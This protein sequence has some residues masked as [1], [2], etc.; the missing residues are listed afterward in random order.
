M[1]TLSKKNHSTH[2]R[3]CTTVDRALLVE[4]GIPDFMI[5]LAGLRRLKSAVHNTEIR[6][7]HD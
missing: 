7:R 4:A 6:V 3:K 5:R 2:A 1:K